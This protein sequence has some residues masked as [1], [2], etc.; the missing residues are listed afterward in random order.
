MKKR[1]AN[2][3]IRMIF[4]VLVTM[5]RNSKNLYKHLRRRGV[6]V[7]VWVLNEEEEFQEALDIFGEQIDGM[8]TDCPTKLVTFVKQ[9]EMM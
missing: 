4:V 2:I 8:M 7:I 3:F 6:P 5:I 1:R 9:W